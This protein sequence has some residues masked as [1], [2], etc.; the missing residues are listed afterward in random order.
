MN[1]IT[2]IAIGI[3]FVVSGLIIG[4]SINRQTRSNLTK[5]QI[6]LLINQKQSEINNLK[7]TKPSQGDNIGEWLFDI[8]K[9]IMFFV[10]SIYLLVYM[11]SDTS[12]FENQK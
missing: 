12:M 8:I 1:N 5:D 4:M 6:D 9:L 2:V 3:G 10:I 11:I 7:S